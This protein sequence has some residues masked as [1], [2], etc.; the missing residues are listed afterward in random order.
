M[1]N[2]DLRESISDEIKRRRKADN[3][4]TAL[5]TQEQL[6]PIIATRWNELSGDPDD[7]VDVRESLTV[8]RRVVSNEMY[9]LETA[10]NAA[11]IVWENYSKFADDE[12]L[13]E[14]E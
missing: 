5:M 11:Q 8:L 3:L 6:F 13:C 7:C 2:F 14:D 10:F 9:R 4:I 12:S 1:N